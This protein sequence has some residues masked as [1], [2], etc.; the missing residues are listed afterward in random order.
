MRLLEL[1]SR[2][3]RNL[4]PDVVSFGSG[5]NLVVGE[6]GQGKTNLLEAI[7]LVCGQRSFRRA[8]PAEMSADGESFRVGARVRRGFAT[9]DLAV[10]WS[11]GIGRRFRRAGKEIS[12]REASSLAP[13][14]F[15]APE[16]RALLAGPPEERRRFLDRLVLGAR[17]AAGADL[18][19]YERAL[20]ERNA[21]LARMQP[22]RRGER[23]P[24][25]PTPGKAELEAWTEEL[26]IAGEAVR[27]HRREALKLFGEAF[28]ELSEDAGPEYAAISLSYSVE[29]GSDLKKTLEEILPVE[30]LRGR[31]LAGPHRD[32][33]VW[34]RAGAH[35]ENRASAGEIHRIVTLAK[36]AEWR[37]VRDAAG[38]PPLFGVD[39]FD[40]GLSARSLDGFFAGLPEGATVILTTASDPSRFRGVAATVLPIAA[41]RPAGAQARAGTGAK[42]T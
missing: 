11:A 4:A 41:G 3:F 36:L 13:A 21:L 16:H 37:V 2:G 28:F 29:E 23:V 30:L 34:R 10:E 20:R 9:E 8:S 31:T 22:Y 19:R 40:A 1:A 7:A 32:D 39:D 12:F 33:L 27:R 26:A 14:V 6:N 17:P 18:V 24:A 15:L 38:E 25:G 42:G 35:L 5:W